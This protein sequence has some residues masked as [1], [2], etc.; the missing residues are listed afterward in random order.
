MTIIH[1][2][3]DTTWSGA[4]GG[5]PRYDYQLSLIVP[6]RI[7]VKGPD[8]KNKLLRILEQNPETIVITDNHLACDVPNTHNC[9]LVHHG[10]ARTTAHYNPAWPEPWKSLCVNGQN[11]MLSYRKTHNTQIISPSEACTTDFTYYYGDEYTKF[12]RHDIL[13]TSELNEQIYKV[14]FDNERPVILGNWNGLKKGANIVEKLKTVHEMNT[15]EFKS[16]YVKLKY[17]NFSVKTSIES[18]NTQKQE[19]YINSDIFLQLSNSEGSA[20]AT[21]DAMLCGLVIVATNVGLFYNNVPENCFVKVEREEMHD[22]DYV[23]RRILHAWKNKE[24]YAKNARDWYMENCRFEDWKFK[25]MT[26]IDSIKH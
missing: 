14:S 10:C 26:V 18:F 1:Y 19:I 7:F 4:V 8:E 5:V 12:K 21:L 9:L 2:C 6:N 13:H 17:D 23:K 24:I 22:V 20:Y 16:L 15:F 3:C 11:K 25:M